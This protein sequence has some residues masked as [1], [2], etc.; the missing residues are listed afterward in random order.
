MEVRKI[1]EKCLQAGLRITLDQSNLQVHSDEQPTPELVELIRVHKAQ[2]IEFLGKHRGNAAGSTQPIPVVPCEQ[3][4]DLSYQQQSLHFVGELYADHSQYNLCRV[5]SYKGDFDVEVAN[6]TLDCLLQRH[7]MLSTRFFEAQG[8]MT[9]NFVAAQAISVIEKD[10]PIDDIWRDEQKY[11]FQLDGSPLLRIVHVVQNSNSGW[12]LFN[13]PHRVV[14]GKSIAIITREFSLIYQALKQGREPQLPV[15]PVRY[16][17]Y[18]VWQSSRAQQDKQA[19]E[20]AFWINRLA[21][22]PPIHGLQTDYSRPAVKSTKG[23]TLTSKLSSDT[24]KRIDEFC[25]SQAVTPFV[26][27]QTLM[28]VLISRYSGEGNVVIG[29]PVENRGHEQLEN[30]VGLFA[31]S[32]AIYSQIDSNLAFSEQLKQNK[33]RIFEALSNQ[34][35][36]LRKVVESLNPERAL[37]YSPLFQLF[38]SLDSDAVDPVELDQVT[39]TPLSLGDMTSKFDLELMV[40]RGNSGATVNWHYDPALFSLDSMTAMDAIYHRLLEQVLSDVEV[41]CDQI[42]LDKVPMLSAV[43]TNS[44]QALHHLIELQAQRS[45]RHIAV[46]DGLTAIDYATL[47]EKSNQVAHYLISNGVSADTFVGVCMPRTV[48]AVIAIVGVLK[49]GAAYLPIDPKLPQQ[50]REYIALDAAVSLVLTDIAEPFWR[51]V[52]MASILRESTNNLNPNIDVRPEHLAY[53]IYTSGSTGNPKGVMITHA[54]V[55]S[56]LASCNRY[57]NLDNTARITNFHSLSFDFSVWELFAALTN[58]GT[59]YMVPESLQLDI[60]QFAHFLIDNQITLLSLTPSVFYLV[61]NELVRMTRAHHLKFVVLGGEALDKQKITHWFESTHSEQVT[62]VNMYGITETT[63]HVTYEEVTLNSK[64]AS[65]GLPLDGYEAYIV[66]QCGKLQPANAPGELW[67]AGTGV[68]RGYLNRPQLSDERFLEVDFEG[69]H[70]RVYKT[71]DLV[72]RNTDG[73]LRYLGRSDQ[74][75]KLRGFRIE[76]GE[77]EVA[78]Q[79]LDNVSAAI[80]DKVSWSCGEQLAAFIVPKSDPAEGWLA[81]I[82]AALKQSLPAYM[83]PTIIKVVDEIPVTHNGKVDK[84]RLTANVEQDGQATRLPLTTTTERELAQLWQQLLDVSEIFADDNFFSLGGHSL[85]IARLVSKITAKF[86]KNIALTVIYENPQLNH[87]AVAIESAELLPERIQRRPEQS[88]V[89]PTVAQRAMWL[90]CQL[91]Q[92]TSKYNIPVT[93]QLNGCVNEAAIAHALQQVVGRHEI[94]RTQFVKLDDELVCRINPSRDMQHLFADLTHLDDAQRV[95]AVQQHQRLEG[96]GG[97]DLARDILLRSR[98]LKVGEQSYY[99]LVTVHHLACDAWSVDVLFKEFGAAYNALREDLPCELPDLDIQYGDYALWQNQRASKE[100]LDS[101]L[102]F[103]R[104]RLS[105]APLVHSLPLDYPRPSVPENLAGVEKQQLDADT[106]RRLRDIAKINQCSMFNVVQS[107]FALLIAQVS[108]ESDIMMVCPQAGRG[109]E[110]LDNMIGL[111]SQNIIYRTKL[112]SDICFS[113]LVSESQQW[114]IEGSKYQLVPYD[115]IVRDVAPTRQYGV[116]PLCQI[117]L[118]FLAPV[119]LP[120]QLSD[121]DWVDVSKEYNIQDLDLHLTVRDTGS[122]LEIR[123]LYNKALFKPQTITAWMA[124]FGKLGESVATHTQTPVANLPSNAWRHY[125]TC[126]YTCAHTDKFAYVHQS[127]EIHA[128]RQPDRIALV[129]E[130]GEISYETLNRIANQYANYLIDKGLEKGQTVGICVDRNV[131]FVIAM[132]AVLK[133]G[134]AYV[135]LVPDHP[136]D[137]LQ[138]IA[139]DADIHFVLTEQ[140][141]I[142]KFEFLAYKRVVPMDSEFSKVLLANFSEADLELDLASPQLQKAYVIYTSGSTGKPKGVQV[143]HSAICNLMQHE[144]VMLEL[145]QQS[146]VLNCFSFSFDPA[147]GHTFSALSAG[148]AVYICPRHQDVASYIE[149]HQLTHAGLPTALAVA[150][151]VQYWPT[152]THVWVGGERCPTTLAASWG[153]HYRFFNLYGPTEAT[154]YAL[155]DEFQEGQDIAIGRPVANTRCYILNKLGQI[156]GVG[157]TGE[158]VIAGMSINTCYADDALNAQKYGTL[159]TAEGVEKIYY[160]GDL[161]VLTEEGRIQYK[162]RLDSQVKIRG[163]RIEPFEVEQQLLALPQINEAA[164]VVK[165]SPSGEVSLVAYYTKCTGEDTSQD[166]T[167]L[168]QKKLPSWMLPS[169]FVVLDELPLTVNGKV[170]IKQLPEPRNEHAQMVS[171]ETPLQQGVVDMWREV[172]SLQDISMVDEFFDIGGNSLVAMILVSQVKSKYA[173]DIQVKDIFECSTPAKFANLLMLKGAANENEEQVVEMEW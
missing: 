120:A 78:I 56:L 71:G 60:G 79:E 109:S 172:L 69:V 37:S 165:Q 70:K 23:E 35:V 127:V 4:F 131:N 125:E 68:A 12:L 72:S 94:F 169:S 2:I 31:N 53:A 136:E 73:T 52:D 55:T 100:L 110:Q 38:F 107:L 45:P 32:V 142:Q 75:L 91:D 42:S 22:C 112:R 80:V 113:Q 61:A 24:N 152:L 74:Q 146:R 134:A 6:R 173:I 164:V 30:V 84:K 63:V 123:W 88:T 98:L 132:L 87:L 21:G 90:A 1:L 36:P 17:D 14:D 15:L 157:Q 18:V 129:D 83:V 137:Y 102:E 51:A 138:E 81:S 99:L 97:F 115:E 85:L 39:L 151:D 62:L 148:A 76:P 41:Q 114:L 153:K 149:R 7:P 108:N 89:Q 67:V 66:N 140:A 121:I 101:G 111:L 143:H 13:L 16:S 139:D 133:A 64:N 49:S 144:S 130:D 50:R 159:V 9:Q 59:L 33:E 65:I 160:T 92:N 43:S 156:A 168:L 124:L 171:P 104:E 118:N 19:Q 47:N 29:T 10:A 150:T 26:L 158:L 122:S 93:L 163:Y 167:Q 161:A 44:A 154:V 5:Y 27:L 166:L 8:C 48:E 170:D 46:N 25:K 82:E 155:Y 57:Y 34:D 162:G 11:Q 128:H 117:A 126:N 58:G 28:A 20:L 135:P 77:V 147:T 54:N 106:Y 40:K 105:H 145:N 116:P 141:L 119:E 3:G 86:G 96:E 103:W 95:E